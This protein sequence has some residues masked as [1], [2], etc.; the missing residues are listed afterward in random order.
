MV[1]L[2]SIN[3]KWLLHVDPAFC[4]SY[5]CGLLGINRIRMKFDCMESQTGFSLYCSQ[6]H[7]AHFLMAQPKLCLLSKLHIR[8]ILAMIS[9]YAV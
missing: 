6:I 5:T 8:R 9:D 4:E 2:I 3:Y 7:Q 1:Y